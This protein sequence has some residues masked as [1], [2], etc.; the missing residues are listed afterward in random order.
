MR[1]VGDHI[2]TTTLDETVRAFVPYALP[3]ANPHL[4]V[5]VYAALNHAAELALARLSG[6]SGLAPS[7]DWLLTAPSVRRRC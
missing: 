6:V 1:I 3:P 2:T 4:P 7:V 5:E